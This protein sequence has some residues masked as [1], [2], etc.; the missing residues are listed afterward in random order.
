MPLLTRRFLTTCFIWT[1]FFIASA[2]QADSAETVVSP[3]GHFE[4][5]NNIRINLHHFLYHLARAEAKQV[6]LRGRVPINPDDQAVEF[7]NYAQPMRQA[8]A[9]YA[10]LID[11]DLLFDERMTNIKNAIADGAIESV[12][13]EIA[14]ALETAMPAYQAL[15]WPQHRTANKAI[16]D[17]LMKQLARWEDVAAHKYADQLESRWPEDPIRVDLS[18]YATRAGA[19]TSSD[20]NHIVISSR[21]DDIQHGYAF[22]ILLHESGHTS[23][24]GDVFYAISVA[25]EKDAGLDNPRYW[26]AVLFFISGNVAADIINDDAYIPYAVKNGLWPEEW[27]IFEK[28][29]KAKKTLKARVNAAARQLAAASQ[30]D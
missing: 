14:Q 3:G 23:P 21:D 5:H 29:W 13:P 16:L 30:K 24:L 9:A 10:D 20:P 11:K 7:G 25:A 8:I 12:D 19:Y 1:P 2:A 15:F 22:E 4:F 26:H 17:I 28:N 18:A 6:K 27:A